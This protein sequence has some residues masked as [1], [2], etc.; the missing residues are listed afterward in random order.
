LWLQWNA[1]LQSP[2]FYFVSGLLMVK[3]VILFHKPDDLDRFENSYNHFLMLVESMPLIRR[4]QVNS[5]L[6][7]PMGETDLYRALEV[8]FDDYAELDQALKS[9]MGQEAGGELVRRFPAA[10]FQMYFAEVYEE[11][12][13]QT[14][15]ST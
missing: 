11:A 13:A 1:G 5:V 7:S 8:Y 12:G 10:T 2:V 4:R 9:P 14:E 15:G 3:F 6:G